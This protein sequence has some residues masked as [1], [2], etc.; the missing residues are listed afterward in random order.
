MDTIRYA[1]VNNG[2][3]KNQSYIM[4]YVP[5]A[6][7][8]SKLNDGSTQANKEVSVYLHLPQYHLRK[9]LQLVTDVILAFL[10]AWLCIVMYILLLFVSGQISD[11]LC[12]A[13]AHKNG[14]LE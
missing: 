7:V 1:Q 6:K 14:W 5:I 8:L 12:T 9:T 2:A 10:D 4:E 11:Q 13:R 3:R